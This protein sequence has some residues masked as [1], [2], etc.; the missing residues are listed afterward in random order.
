MSQITGPD[1]LEKV[2]RDIILWTSQTVNGWLDEDQASAMPRQGDG[3][4]S[5]GPSDPVSGLV[6]AGRRTGARDRIAQ[7]LLRAH[8]ALRDAHLELTPRAPSD[9]C[10]CCKVE[11][12]TCAPDA[13]GVWTACPACDRYRREWGARCDEDVHELRPRVRMCEC[14]EACCEPGTCADRAEEGRTVSERCRKRQYRA[15]Q[16]AS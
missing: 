10:R 11:M 13:H 16:Q 2:A 6:S 7:H 12:A 4:S 3:G 9:P 14:P 1:H 8:R 5:P 15:R